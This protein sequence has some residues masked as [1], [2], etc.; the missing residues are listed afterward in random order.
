MP[1]DKRVKSTTTTTT[2]T[3]M[4]TTLLRI[5]IPWAAKGPQA[6]KR[7]KV[8]L[9]SKHTH[10]FL[11]K[12]DGKA[13]YD[14]NCCTSSKPCSVGNGDCDTDIECSGSLK[15]GYNNC[16][17]TGTYFDDLAD[18]CYQPGNLHFPKQM[19]SLYDTSLLI[20]LLSDCRYSLL[21][22]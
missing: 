12:C 15:C 2:T 5:T 4:I 18:C 8:Q 14:L 9:L 19:N 7:W 21:D 6:K 20:F 11:V 13:T 22:N 3:T 16:V 10:K 17:R 1:G